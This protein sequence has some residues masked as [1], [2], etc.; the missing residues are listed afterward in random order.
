MKKNKCHIPVVMADNR[1]TAT[2]KTIT[3]FI[4][5][6]GDKRCVQSAFP[7]SNDNINLYISLFPFY[8]VT[9]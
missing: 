7:T 3:D 9:V 1:R 5:I 2:H 6:L 8:A 4:L